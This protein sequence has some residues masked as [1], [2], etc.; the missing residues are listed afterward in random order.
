MPVR[1]D[2]LMGIAHWDGPISYGELAP[3]MTE[4]LNERTLRNAQRFAFAGFES[5]ELLEKAIS[6]RGTGP[7]MRTYRIQL[8]EKLVI[9]NEFR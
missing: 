3:G 6:L 7:K 2:M 8:G 4:V 1:F 5:S 9:W